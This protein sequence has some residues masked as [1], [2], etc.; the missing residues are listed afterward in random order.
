MARAKTYDLRHVYALVGV[1][2]ISGYGEDGSIE[3]EWMEDL[4]ELTVGSDGEEIVFSRNNNN[5]LTV[6]ITLMETSTAYRDMMGLMAAQQAL[7]AIVP[8]PFMMIDANNGD[9][10]VDSYAVFLTRSAPSKG[11][12]AGSREFKIALPD[13]KVVF[14]ILNSP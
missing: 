9:S 5:V 4:G 7:I 1:Y 8:L 12:K 14:G 3:F 13:P 2:D 11:K 10:V 6:T